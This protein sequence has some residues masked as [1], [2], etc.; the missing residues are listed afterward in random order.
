MSYL[1][2][3]LE[4]YTAACQ[5]NNAAALASLS[6]GASDDCSPHWRE[7]LRGVAEEAEAARALVGALTEARKGRVSIG[8]TLYNEQGKPSIFAFTDAPLTE[9]AGAVWDVIA[10]K[11]EAILKAPRA[12]IKIVRRDER[13]EDA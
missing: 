10:G 4:Q 1:D 12:E 3:L 2:V 5:R 6:R 9:L 8:V 7:L 13:K 11:R